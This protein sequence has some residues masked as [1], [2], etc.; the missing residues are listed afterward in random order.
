[1]EK[2]NRTTNLIN[3]SLSR[4]KLSRENRYRRKKSYVDRIIEFNFIQQKELSVLMFNICIH[5]R[6]LFFMLG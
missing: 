2:Q 3:S 6:L 5:Y 1:M 4:K